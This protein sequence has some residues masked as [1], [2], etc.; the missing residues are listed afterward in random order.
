MFRNAAIDSGEVTI[1]VIRAFSDAT[2][3][4]RSCPN[5]RHAA[6]QQQPTFR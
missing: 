5:F 3:H 4:V 6:T 2:R 1:W